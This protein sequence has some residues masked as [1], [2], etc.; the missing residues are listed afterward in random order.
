MTIC[1]LATPRPTRVSKFR[2]DSARF[3]AAQFVIVCERGASP[4][5]KLA[6]RLPVLVR[7]TSAG[8]R[9]RNPRFASAAAET[10]RANRELAKAIH[11]LRIE[12]A[13]LNVHRDRL[14]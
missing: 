5:K 6:W 12:I 13:K 2:P 10:S 11:E 9:Q 3:D 4:A 1:R 8:V 14:P 7:K